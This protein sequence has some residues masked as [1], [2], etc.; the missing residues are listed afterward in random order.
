[1]TS[2]LHF[3]PE[4]QYPSFT[5][6]KSK[7]TLHQV[8]EL[9]KAK[10]CFLLSYPCVSLW[11]GYFSQEHSNSCWLFPSWFHMTH[12]SLELSAIYSYCLTALRVFFNKFN[13]IYIKIRYEE[14]GKN[15]LNSTDCMKCL[16]DWRCYSHSWALGAGRALI[17]FHFFKGAIYTRQ[18]LCGD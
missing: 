18:C 8:L 13:V 1:M 5:L 2:N 11:T 9:R 16:C 7:L 6:S 15:P 12:F 4:N 10:I 17:L 3:L 14:R